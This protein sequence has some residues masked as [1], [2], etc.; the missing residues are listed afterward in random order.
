MA[1]TEGFWKED[2]QK[3]HYRVVDGAYQAADLSCGSLEELQAKYLEPF[4]SLGQEWARGPMSPYG[5]AYL[6]NT[7]AP[8]RYIV[9]IS[10][11]EPMWKAFSRPL[12]LSSGYQP[13]PKQALKDLTWLVQ[14]HLTICF[15][16]LQG[17]AGHV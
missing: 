11:G 10:D 15:D 12:G 16:T 7:E 6:E 8:Y 3:Y 1:D 14:F 17:L 2:G 13:S 5:K 9:D 4:R